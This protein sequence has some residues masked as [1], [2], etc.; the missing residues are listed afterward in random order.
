VRGNRLFAFDSL[1]N[2]VY[3]FNFDP[4]TPDF[5]QLASFQIPTPT[6]LFP[7]EIVATPDGAL[8]YAALREEDAV[9]VLDAGE[10]IAGTPGA[11][12]TKIHTGLAP[13]TLAI[14]PGL[15]TPTGSN[16][17]VQPISE[18]TISFDGITTAGETSVATTNTSPTPVPAGFQVG[19]PPVFFEIST[20]ATFTGPIEVCFHY[21]QGQFQG[22]E[23]KLRILH[24]ENGIFVDRTVSVD[25]GQNVICALVDG[26]S[27]FVVGVGSVDFLFDTLLRNI[28]DAVDQQGIRRSLQ[29][30]VLAARAAVDRE[31]FETARNL[32]A[33]FQSEL[34]A[35]VGVHITSSDQQQ[36]SD[37]AQKIV[38]TF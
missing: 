9:A 35:L 21:E 29:A 16:V 38:G 13:S 28:A 27:R 17:S 2:V 20:T 6:G 8:L 24:E 37:L 31:Q 32:L 22:P 12:L 23:S 4:A 19:N 25:P 14:R 10:I 15:A 1:R 30:K 7:S 33:A 5:Q 26:F 11:L 3:V 36:L 18:V 34:S